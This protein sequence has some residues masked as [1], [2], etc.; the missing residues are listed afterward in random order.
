MKAQEDNANSNSLTCLVLFSLDERSFGLHLSAVERVFHIVEVTSLPKAPRCVLGIINLHGTIVPVFNIRERFGLP[1]RATL[2]S[3]QLVIAR[4]TKRTVAL[5]VDSVSGVV[6]RTPDN[7][8][9]TREILPGMEYVEGVMRLEDDLI[10]IHNL[11]TFLSLDEEMALEVA[12]E[13]Q[14]RERG[15]GIGD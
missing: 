7:S 6:D 11:E 1:E 12:L 4:T 2:L 3:D 13:D 10:F 8:T 9:P 5:L 15:L 14:I